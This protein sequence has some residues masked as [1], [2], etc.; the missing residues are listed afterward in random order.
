MKSV[1]SDCPVR[2]RAVFIWTISILS[3]GCIVG[4]MATPNYSPEITVTRVAEGIEIDGEFGDRGW[5]SAASITSFVERFPGDNTQPDVPTRALV[6]YDDKYLYVAFVCLDDPST[7][8]ATMCQR[9][10]FS[11][12]DAVALMLDTYGDA[13]WAYHLYVNPYGIQ[14]DY[15]WTTIIGEDPGFDLIWKS[16]AKIT[17]SGYQVEIAVPFSSLRF[18]D[19]DIQSWRMNFERIRPRESYHQ[20]SWAARDRNEP[21]WPCQ[22]GTGDGIASVQPGK[23]LELLPAYVAFQS[24]SLSDPGNPRSGFDNQDVMGELS[25]GGKYTVS[26]DIVFE[27]AFNPDFSQIESDAAQVDVNTTIALFFPER[28]PFFQEGSDVFRTLFNSFYTRTVNDPEYAA[29]IVSRKAGFT[30]GAMTA[31]DENTV[32][33]VP[34]EE[35]S[36]LVMAGRSWVNVLRGTKSVGDASQIGFILTDRRLEGGGYG[37]IAAVDGDIRITQTLAIDG[38]LIASFTGE[39]D[40]PG[41]SAGLGGI[42]FDRGKRTAMFD[43][44]SFSGNAAIARLRRFARHWSFI[45]AYSQVDPSYRTETGYDPWVDY[46]DGEATTWYTFYPKGGLFQQV[47]PEVSANAR[48]DYGGVRR[49][50][51]QNLTINGTLRWA[52]TNFRLNVFRGTEAWTSRISGTLVDYDDLYGANFYIGSRISD[53]L[54][55]DLSLNRRRQVAR[56]AESVGNQNSVQLTLSLKPIDRLVIVPSTQLVQSNDL[57]S[58]QELYR[59]V[60]M[61]TRLNLQVNRELSVRLIVQ[62]DDSRAAV[63]T[64]DTERGRQYFRVSDRSWEVDPLITYRIGSFSVLHAGS[65]HSYYLFPETDQM[66]GDTWKLSSRQFFVKLQ[67]LFQV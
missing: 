57:H 19:R 30:L 17:D 3:L 65:T 5:Y 32:Y 23:G 20:Y 33:M 40:K 35:S 2:V 56:F 46:R 27:A 63:Y 48:W 62:H 6:A 28:R 36:R 31:Q 25:L 12:N 38:Q 10:Q 50:E 34:L 54:G 29:K 53:K 4:P 14:K 13:S 7:V 61:R 52:Q 67:Y 55:Y 60:I 37:S 9:D 44:E 11:G 42:R 8:R 66:S 18:P 24:G 51:Y 41:T 47:R 45:A 22:W 64:G 43:G 21:C 58:D 15:L 49:W 16:A 39:P 1:D 26:S 59:Q